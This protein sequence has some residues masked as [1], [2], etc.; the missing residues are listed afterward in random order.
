M[1]EFI[2]SE[3]QLENLA[4][5]GDDGV[6]RWAVNRL[7]VLYP[8]SAERALP[9]WLSVTA[10]Q[11]VEEAL[12]HLSGRR[13]EELVPLLRRLYLE[14]SE[15]VSAKAIQIAGDWGLVEAVGWMRVRILEHRRLARGQ[16]LAMIHALGQIPDGDAY[17]LLK[18]TE[19]SIQDQDPKSDQWQYFHAALLNHGHPQD[20]RALLTKFT[21]GALPEQHRRNMLGILLAHFDVWLN[22]TDVFYVNRAA[23]GRHF[24]ARL[25][26]LWEGEVPAGA[27]SLVG[28]CRLAVEQLGSKD[29]SPLCATLEGLLTSLEPQVLAD[30][31]R[32][33]ALAAVSVLSSGELAEDARFGVACV[34]LSA[35]LTGIERSRLAG[36][37]GGLAALARI[38]L[39]LRRHAPERG[40]ETLPEEW[41]ESADR[42]LLTAELLSLLGQERRGPAA[43]RAVEILGRLRAKEALPLVAQ[44]VSEARDAFHFGVLRSTLG[45]FGAALTPTLLG[46][47]ESG[48]AAERNI[49]QALLEDLPTGQVV[50]AIGER[51]PSLYARDPAATLHTLYALGAADFIPLLEKEY[52]PGEVDLGRVYLHLC[53]LHGHYPERFRE[54]EGELK[55]REVESGAGER[56][57]KE[58]TAAKMW[59]RVLSLELRCGECD[60]LYHYDIHEVHLHPAGETEGMQSDEYDP[61]R[62]GIVIR[63]DVACKNCRAVNRILLTP[64]TVQ[65]LSQEMV[66]VMAFSKARL[67]I[68]DDYPVKLVRWPGTEG[69]AKTLGQI[70]K[71]HREAVAQHGSRPLSHLA[72]GKFLEYTKRYGEARIAYLQALDS[73]A[74]SVE[75]LAGLARIDQARG[76]LDD[77]LGWLESCHEL[78]DRG[79]YYLTEDKPAFK[80]MVRRVRRELARALGQKPREQVVPVP[81]RLEVSEHPRNK[82]CPCGSGKKYKLCCL[83]GASK[84]GEESERS[85]PS[86]G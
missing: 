7:F 36:D 65:Q 83:K 26:A 21:E 78:L 84:A 55:R 11:R 68:P 61:L 24:A 34:A 50:Q 44:A 60:K 16:V 82:P 56:R 12:D 18:S 58:G 8:L 70:E 2:W 49:A 41:L 9:L 72:L 77:A 63:D 74:R 45:Q 13:R 6:R 86:D 54:I 79:S 1:M 15:T 43:M 32:Q 75:A 33:A 17:S 19:E 51:Y 53:R 64:G 59:P 35:V 40:V 39:W 81:F 62:Q 27:A 23:T 73:D 47:L 46:W 31:H 29:F 48:Q 52:R 57:L 28:H 85:S 20:V 22:P 69:Q 71:E 3:S 4:G 5:H 42:D 67:R 38:R 37:S 14:G 76:A 10:G 66:K 80:K 30:R 25:E